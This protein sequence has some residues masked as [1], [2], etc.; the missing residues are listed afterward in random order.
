MENYDK[1]LF[2]M[3]VKFILAMCDI[4]DDFIDF[5]KKLDIITWQ[6]DNM[7]E[8]KFGVK[9]FHEINAISQG[10]TR[11]KSKE[12]KKFYN[13]NKSI[14]DKINKHIEIK[15]FITDYL[16]GKK[17]F[18]ELYNYI[19]KNKS[20]IDKIRINMEKLKELGIIL[21]KFDEKYD[22]T[23]DVYQLS[24]MFEQNNNQG[25]ILFGPQVVYLENLEAIPSYNGLQYKSND[26]SYKLVCHAAYEGNKLYAH[27]IIMNDLTIDVNRLPKSLLDD[28]IDS[29]KKL[30]QEKNKEYLSV[31]E[32]V[33]LNVGIEDL[34]KALERFYETIDR[35]IVTMPNEEI[36]K[37]LTEIKEKI[38]KLKNISTDYDKTVTTKYDSINQD[39]LAEEKKKYLKK[40]EDSKIDLC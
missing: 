14:I 30:K 25:L 17:H 31:K 33:L 1:S 36:V 28:V 23:K 22:F 3:N 4:L 35:N 21:L 5:T 40:R 29:I 39:L 10:K 8:S 12:I 16:H 15:L 20:N 38:M 11:F 34:E 2:N 27:Y 13:E 18:L 9:L 24:C 26:S 37:L 7:G 19:Q 6:R 32:S